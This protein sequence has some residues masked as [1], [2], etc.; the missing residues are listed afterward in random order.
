M[1][2]KARREEIAKLKQKKRLSLNK[3]TLEYSH[4]HLWKNQACPC[5]CITCRDEKYRDRPRVKN[6]LD[7]L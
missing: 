4:A 1:K 7:E 3:L 6:H 5:S 2:N